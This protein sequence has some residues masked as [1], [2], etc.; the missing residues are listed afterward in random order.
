[1]HRP[2][3]NR[4]AR[5]H[6]TENEMLDSISVPRSAVVKALVQWGYLTS[7]NVSDD[8]LTDAVS[9][10]QSFN[11][12]AAD[13]VVGPRTVHQM[14]SPLRCGLPDMMLDATCAWPHKKVTYLPRLQLPGITN[15]DMLRA[16]DQ[17]CQQWN[18]V[19][20]IQLTRVG[21]KPANIVADS[22]TGQGVNLDGRGGTLAWSYLPCGQSANGSLQ[23]MYDTGENWSFQML[24]A[25]VC[26][27]VGHAIGLSHL[28][29][30]N[31]LAPYYSAEIT[32]P[33]AGDIAEAVKRYGA[34]QPSAPVPVPGA[35]PKV[36]VFV[37]IGGVRYTAKG[38]MKVAP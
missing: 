16:F 27:E 8:E 30:G 33:Q 13:G 22:G 14:T 1:M 38:T 28:S 35:E 17:A 21:G 3:R 9:R 2:C 36:E 23:Q 12:L 37:E 5:S 18:A 31:L 15:E 25:V 20:G 32:K 19:C 6:L 29:A 34:P 24:V 10:Y 26:H 7:E 11:G 4:A